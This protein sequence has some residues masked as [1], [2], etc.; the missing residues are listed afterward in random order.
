VDAGVGVVA[1][2]C[3]CV[4]LWTTGWFGL[5]WPAGW[6][7]SVDRVLFNCGGRPIE[8]ESLRGR[9]GQT[10]QISFIYQ[11]LPNLMH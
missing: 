11:R 2:V 9:A 6:N 1:L 3:V 5:V 10:A 8:I 7:G 4:V